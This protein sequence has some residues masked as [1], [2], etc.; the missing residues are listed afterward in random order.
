METQIKQTDYKSMFFF[1]GFLISIFAVYVALKLNSFEKA[2]IPIS[3]FAIIMGLLFEYRRISQKWSYVLYMTLGSFALGF[4]AMLAGKEEGAN[5]FDKD[6]IVLPLAFLF[7]FV[8]IAVVVHE[9]NIIAHLTEG[10]TLMQSIAFI[11]F[12]LD[13]GSWQSRFILLKLLVIIAGLLSLFVIF[14]SLSNFKLSKKSR[15][16]LSIWS[17]V[18]MVVLAADNI[19]HV[20][21]NEPIETSNNFW[22]ASYIGTQYFLLGITSIY[23]AQNFFML[24]D[25]LPDRGGNS[26][27]K[28]FNK[29]NHLKAKHVARY[30]RQQIKKSQGLLCIL[31]TSIIF[32]LNYYFRF[33][34]RSFAIWSVFILFP[35]IAD[36]IF[37]DKNITQTVVLKAESSTNA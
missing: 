23:I 35:M 19:F 17:S 28:Y 14:Y 11:Y 22:Q 24:M 20:Y 18:I 1:L 21:L 30:S 13:T 16:R 3:M 4:F 34:P 37:N 27:G 31:L 5:L 9:K 33:V 7:F 29:I 36:F 10:I 12:I 15:L 2:Y 6:I 26:N 8:T 25:F 32:G